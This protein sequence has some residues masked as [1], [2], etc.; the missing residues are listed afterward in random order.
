MPVLIEQARPDAQISIEEYLGL[1]I[2]LQMSE[3]V[4]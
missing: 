1:G 2:L 4:T 3:T